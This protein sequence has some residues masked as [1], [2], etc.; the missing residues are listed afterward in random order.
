MV[1]SM[2][3]ANVSLRICTEFESVLASVDYTERIVTF[4]DNDWTGTV[5]PGAQ[6]LDAAGAPLTLE[7]FVTGEAVYV[8]G[9]P[10]SDGTLKI[11][12]MSKLD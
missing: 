3:M 7:D 6:L 5:C 1:S 12:I 8:K 10:A 9:F 2:K 4:D 11:C